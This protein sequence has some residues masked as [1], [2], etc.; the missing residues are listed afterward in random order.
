MDLFSGSPPIFH[1]QIKREKDMNK[2]F[3]TLE[4]E[5]K[6]STKLFTANILQS[7]DK[8]FVLSNAHEIITASGDTPS[9]RTCNRQRGD[10]M[11]GM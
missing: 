3:R 9:Q 6:V 5:R 11:Y 8:D 4:R 2:I 7:S 10:H 1:H